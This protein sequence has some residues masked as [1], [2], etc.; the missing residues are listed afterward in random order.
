[1][2]VEPFCEGGAA[3]LRRRLREAIGWVRH[4]LR[5]VKDPSVRRKRERLAGAVHHN[6]GDRDVVEV[7]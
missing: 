4:V 6:V 2:K 3:V 1:M 5:D 7:Q